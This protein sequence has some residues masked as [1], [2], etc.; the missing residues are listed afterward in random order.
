MNRTKVRDIIDALNIIT[1]GRIPKQYDIFSGEN[2]FVMIKSSSIPGKSIME[3]P[4]LVFGDVNQIIKKLAVT[5]TLTE[6]DIELANALGVDAIVA[7]HPIADAANSG[8]VTLKNYL[9]LYK[10]SVFEVHE[11]FHGLH[12]GISYLH[13]HKVFR[14]EI[15]YG[16]IPG[17]IIFVGKTLEGIYTLGDMLDWTLNFMD[18]Q[19]EREFLK[20]ERD[21]RG[22][23]EINETVASLEGEI[24]VGN[25]ESPVNIILHIFPHTGFNVHHLE[26]VKK[27]HPDIDTVLASISRVK[28]DNPI[29][30]KCRSLGL[31]F[32]VGNSHALEIFEN[33][34]P[35]A[36]AL[37]KIIPEIEIVI[38]RQRVTA[39]PI[40]N[41]GSSQINEYAEMMANKYL[42]TKA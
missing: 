1:G 32:I 31:N 10:I 28:E 30:E 11:A 7:H 2:P 9:S 8:G 39:T 17:N 21:I 37:N 14:T 4:G 16:G 22:C 35:L 36:I 41:F 40:N 34:L 23:D 42:V 24:L 29:V 20:L 26:Q 19:Q 27:E 3:I 33:G 25:R 38:F 6:S 13:G 18:F 15:A 5:M 12:P